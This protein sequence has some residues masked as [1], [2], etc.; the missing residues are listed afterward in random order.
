MPGAELTEIVGEDQWTATMHVK[1]G[2]VA[3]RFVTDITRDEVDEP[4][5]RVV[6]SAKAREAHGRGAARATVESRLV[7]DLEQTEVVI[8]TDLTLQG[9]IAQYG[10]GVVADVST[11]LTSR[12]AEC[13]ARQLSPAGQ[14]TPSDAL[15]PPPAESVEA[16]GGIGLLLR[17]LGASFARLVRWPGHRDSKESH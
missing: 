4:A 5:K 8:T 13:L 12:F 2:P 17:A 10:R 16:I 14:L 6:L 11:Q 3:L 7:Q 9:S 1:L 15:A